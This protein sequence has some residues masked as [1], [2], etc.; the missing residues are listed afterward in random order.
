MKKFATFALIFAFCLSMIIVPTSAATTYKDFN[1]WDL[2]E[3][4]IEVWFADVVYQGAVVGHGILHHSAGS[5][6][7]WI[8]GGSDAI[9]RTEYQNYNLPRNFGSN[10][11][12]NVTVYAYGEGPSGYDSETY[13]WSD[14]GYQGG[15]T[16]GW[17]EARAQTFDPFPTYMTGYVK[18]TTPAGTDTAHYRIYG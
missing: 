9:I 15:N 16:L 5:E 11:G 8:F 14:Q 1:D 3:S 2:A 18:V 12:I 4:H 7:W 17:I 10:N 6:G 13:S